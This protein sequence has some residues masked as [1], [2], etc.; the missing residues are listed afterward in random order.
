MALDMRCLTVT[1]TMPDTVE[2]SV[3]RGVGSCGCTISSKEIM[4]TSLYLALMNRPTN[5][6]STEG[7]ITCFKCLLPTILFH[8]VW[9]VQLDQVCHLERSVPPP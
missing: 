4:S 3:C 7:A 9:Y 8:Y 1:L 5:Y 2:L 6:A